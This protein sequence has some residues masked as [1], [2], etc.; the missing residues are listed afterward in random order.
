MANNIAFMLN[1]ADWMV[2]DEDLI[3][4]R[5]KVL[6]VNLFEPL[7]RSGCYNFDCLIVGGGTIVA[8]CWI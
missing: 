6:L 2:Q 5:S 1:L 4:I 7:E 3:N 8:T